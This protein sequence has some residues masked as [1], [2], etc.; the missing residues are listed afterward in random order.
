MSSL[1]ALFALLLAATLAAA[2]TPCDSLKLSLPDTTVTSIQFVA[3]GPFA[4]PASTEAA[5]PA[6]PPAG[7]GGGRGGAAR[8]GGPDPNGA[9][10]VFGLAY[11][12]RC[13]PSRRKLEWKT[14]GSGKRRMGRH[15][16]LS[17]NGGGPARGLRGSFQRHGAQSQ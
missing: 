16:Q 4:A 10:A 12:S 9:D 2:Q 7:R 5:V 14:P 3:A 6:V 13:I 1:Y 17:G 8:G 11:R 15:R